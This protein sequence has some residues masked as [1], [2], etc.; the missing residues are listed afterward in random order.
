MQSKIRPNSATLGHTNSGSSFERHC[1]SWV[2]VTIWND[3][4]DVC[5]LQASWPASLIRS[6]N[7]PIIKGFMGAS[8]GGLVL[9]LK[10]FVL[11]TLRDEGAVCCT[12]PFSVAYFLTQLDLHKFHRE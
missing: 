9:K 5:N 3:C 8:L 2:S 10:Q 1:K 6:E 11:G 12:E 7:A 4:Y